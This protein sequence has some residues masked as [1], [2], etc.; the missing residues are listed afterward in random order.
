MTIGAAGGPTIITQVVQGLI[1]HLD[2]QEPLHE[3]IAMPRIHHQWKP[4]N[5]YVEK[6]MPPAIRSGL[7]AKGHATKTLWPYGSTQAI[8]VDSQGQFSSVAE[9]RLKA[10]NKVQ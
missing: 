3:A 1:N 8:V 7:E 10:R 5:L 4:N 9:P 2:L 6:T